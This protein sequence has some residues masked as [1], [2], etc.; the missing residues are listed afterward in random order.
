MS[1][2]RKKWYFFL[3]FSPLSQN[4]RDEE[5]SV[6]MEDPGM[7]PEMRL[8]SREIPRRLGREGR[9][10]VCQRRWCG[11]CRENG[12][13]WVKIEVGEVGDGGRDRVGF[14][15][16]VIWSVNEWVGTYIEEVWRVR[17]FMSIGLSPFFSTSSLLC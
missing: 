1:Y 15:V 16:C 9:E 11:W 10:G 12:V 7:V 3:H 4:R 6:A 2:R 17:F 5:V 14:G 8:P 13:W